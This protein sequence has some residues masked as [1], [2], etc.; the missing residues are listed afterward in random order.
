MCQMKVG[1]FLYEVND[2]N[3][4]LGQKGYADYVLFGKDGLP[5]AV[6]EA[7]RTGKYPNNG[8]TQARLYAESLERRF[9]Y[10]FVLLVRTILH[11][12]A[13]GLSDCNEKFRGHHRSY[14]EYPCEQ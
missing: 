2:M 14:G 6:I 10:Q 8:I 3:G 9:G 11:D 13:V 12:Q 7:K 4:V 5:L 1:N